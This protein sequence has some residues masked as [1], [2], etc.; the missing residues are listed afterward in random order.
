[1]NWLWHSSR[2]VRRCFSAASILMAM[3]VLI[4]CLVASVGLLQSPVAAKGSAAVVP[5]AQESA[6]LEKAQAVS[7]IT[8][9]VENLPLSIEFFERVLDFELIWRDERWGEDVEELYG[10]FGAR[11]RS[12]RLR[13][14]SEE[15]EL[16]EFMTPKGRLIPRDSRSNDLWFQHIAIVVSDIE[17]AYQRLRQHDIRH[18]ST[19]PQTLPLSNPN[20]GGISAFYFRD[21]DGHVLEIIHFPAGKGDPRWQEA[22][23]TGATFLGIDHTAIVVSDTDESLRFYR[24]ELGLS[25]AGGSENVGTEQAHL[26]NVKDA[27]LRITALKAPG[28]GPGV[29]L[30]EYLHPGPGRAYPPDSLANDLWNWQTVMKVVGSGEGRIVRDPDGHAVLLIP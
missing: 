16:I 24:E 17:A 20:A 12:A 21:P 18:A 3:A 7:H 9:S 30:L 13:L 28:G 11:I 2:P 22:A 6:E 15:I 25:I 4:A 10:I 14:G 27:H 8:I 29:E 1:M 5:S 23:A 19:A 26:N